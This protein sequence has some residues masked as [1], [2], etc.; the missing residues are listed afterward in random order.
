VVPLLASGSVSTLTAAP[1]SSAGPDDSAS[2]PS[3]PDSPRRV[4]TGVLPAL[5][6]SAGLVAV[7]FVTSGGVDQ[8]TA[9]TGNTWTEIVLTLLGA[10]AIAAAAVGAGLQRGRPWGAVTVGLMAALTALTGLSILWSVVPDTS[11]S[12]ANQ[13]L[14][15]LSAF[16]GAAALARLAPGRWPTLLGA[17]ALVTVAI[18]GWALLAKVF[19]ATLAPDNLSGRLQAPFGYWNAV[20]IVGALALPACLW[21][22]AR[23]DR[24]RRL[25]GLA[26]PGITLALSVIVLSSS[27]SADAAAAVVLALWLA[28]VPLR[29]RSVV[30]LAVGGAGA[31]VVSAWGLS[32]PAL[33]ASVALTPAMDSAGHTFGVVLAIVLA[34]VTAAGLACAWAMDHRAGSAATRRRAGTALVVLACLIPVA[35]VGAVA[36]SSRGLTGQISHAWNS[37]TSTHAV[38][39]NNPGRVLQFGSSRPMYWHQGLDVGAHAL[40]KGVGA[41]GYGTARLRYTT[42]PYK[43]DQAHSYVIE[44]FADLGLLGIAIT[45]ALLLAWARAALRP[46]APGTSEHSLTGNQRDER[47]GMV[48]LALIVIGFGIESTLDWTWYFPGVSVP[49]LLCAGWLIGRGPLAA[50]VGWLRPRRSLLDRPG[51]VAIAATAAVIALGAAWLQWQPQHSAD[52]VN[53]SVNAATNAQAFTDARDA[54]SSDPLALEPRFALAALY[55]SVNDIPAARA[56]LTDAVNIQPRNPATWEHLGGFELQAGEPQRALGALRHVAEFDHS[57]DVTTRNANAQIA[58]AQAEIAQAAAAKRRA[59][60]KAQRRSRRRSRAAK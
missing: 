7:A 38:V 20:G 45:L 33:T 4:V 12:S 50:P 6:L 55:Q 1:E 44:T 58:Q 23:R 36:T 18:S 29:Q 46:I 57:P 37:L 35:A 9:T 27:R 56:Q 54:T 60:I 13:M 28:F 24:G 10:G 41:S 17:I 21:S 22:G 34:L 5:C 30:V 32:H 43:S 42:Q 11:W 26:A 31:A 39:F 3:P 59:A 19:P 15:Y 53:A 52:Q 16:A 25:A 49:V 8:T 2:S 40:F 14:S 47:A 51:A 48:A